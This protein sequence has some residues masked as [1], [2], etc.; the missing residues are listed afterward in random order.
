MVRRAWAMLLAAML[1]ACAGI[2]G[3]SKAPHIGQFAALVGACALAAA[4]QIMGGA[5]TTS[6]L[7]KKMSKFLCMCETNYHLHVQGVGLSAA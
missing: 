1:T 2:A 4:L 5:H 3:F 6:Y 7:S